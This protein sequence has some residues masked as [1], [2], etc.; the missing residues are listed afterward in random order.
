MTVSFS[1]ASS[2]PM[3]ADYVM[4]PV[5]LVATTTTSAR[6]MSTSVALRRAQAMRQWGVPRGRA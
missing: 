6:P 3:D 1:L 5:P 2:Q 4:Y